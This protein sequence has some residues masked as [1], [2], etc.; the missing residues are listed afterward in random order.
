MGVLLPRS[1]GVL[2]SLLL[3]ALDRKTCQHGQSTAVK[4]EIFGFLK[5][6]FFLLLLSFL[7]LYYLHGLASEAD[8]SLYLK[9]EIKQCGAL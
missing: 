2:S 1:G 9:V 7:F 6:I 3:E 4:W 8:M 5:I